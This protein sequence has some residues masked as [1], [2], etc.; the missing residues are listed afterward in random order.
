MPSCCERLL[1]QSDQPVVATGLSRLGLNQWPIGRHLAKRYPFHCYV[2]WHI[3]GRGTLNL[4]L[5]IAIV[6]PLLC[7]TAHYDEVPNFFLSCSL[8]HL[9]CLRA[10]LAH[11]QATWTSQTPHEPPR[12]AATSAWATPWVPHWAHRPHDHPSSAQQICPL[13]MCAPHSALG[14]PRAPAGDVGESN[15]SLTTPTRGD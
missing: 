5:V 6:G 11:M 1:V 7:C 3:T 12:R 13:G 15:T 9:G 8:Q 4:G 2:L 10:S 14:E